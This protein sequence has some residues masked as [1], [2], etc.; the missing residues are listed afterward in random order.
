CS[1]GFRRDRGRRSSDHSL[2]WP[3]REVAVLPI[4][5]TALAVGGT[6]L[7]ASLLLGHHGVDHGHDFGHAGSGHEGPE[8]GLV[9]AFLSVRFWTFALA[10]FGLT[11][12][13]F[14]RVIP[15]ADGKQVLALATGAGL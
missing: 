7:A 6:L 2:D 9:A 11:G 14:E 4:Y 5:A 12:V 13:I 3:S 1:S 15:L 10:F 8:L